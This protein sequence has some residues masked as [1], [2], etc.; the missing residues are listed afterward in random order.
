MRKRVIKLNE[1]DL[2]RLV[3]KVMVEQVSTSEFENKTVNFYKD[4][5]NRNF[6]GRATIKKVSAPDEEGVYT[7]D[8]DIENFG[9]EVV[10]WSCEYSNGFTKGRRGQSTPAYNKALQDKM[11]EM[12]CTKGSGGT[13]VSKADFPQ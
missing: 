9:P 13:S 7:I 10:F 3:K 11:R 4:Q 2:I 6:M 8:V 5:A 1:S 12:F